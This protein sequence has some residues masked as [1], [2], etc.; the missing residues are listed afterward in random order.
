[1]N[2]LVL[3]YTTFS[4]VKEAKTVSEELL[5]KK[6]IICANIFPRVN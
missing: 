5:N 1:M 4:N 2:S 6:L 3:V